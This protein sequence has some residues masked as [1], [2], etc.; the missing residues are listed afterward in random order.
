MRILTIHVSSMWYNATQKT[1]W[2]NLL[3]SART[4]NNR[5]PWPTVAV[6][7]LTVNVE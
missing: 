4:G 5:L 3:L 2:Q 7:D 6:P 1:G